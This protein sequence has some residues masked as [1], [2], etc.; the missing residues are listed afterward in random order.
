MTVKVQDIALIT[1]LLLKTDNSDSSVLCDRHS[2][3]DENKVKCSDCKQACDPCSFDSE[4]M[5]ATAFCTECTEYLCKTCLR[6]HKKNKMTRNHQVLI[7]NEVPISKKPFE[8]LK[9]LVCCKNHPEHEVEYRCVDHKEYICSICESRYHRKCKTVEE[10]EPF[11]DAGKDHESAVSLLQ[12]F[13]RN[14]NSLQQNNK[15]K[16]GNIE[17]LEENLKNVNDEIVSIVKDVSNLLFQRGEESKR[18]AKH[19]VDEQQTV[20]RTSV[21]K[22]NALIAEQEDEQQIIRTALTYGSQKQ[23]YLVSQKMNETLSD[24]NSRMVSVVGKDKYSLKLCGSKQDF[25]SLRLCSLTITDNKFQEDISASISYDDCVGSDVADDNQIDSNISHE[26]EK[27]NSEKAN[28]STKSTQTIGDLLG[29]TVLEKSL[30]NCA[31]QFVGTHNI[32]QTGS[33][34]V[35]NINGCVCFDDTI[36]LIDKDNSVLLRFGPHFA[37]GSM[38]DLKREPLGICALSGCSVA[39]ILGGKK[40]QRYLSSSEGFYLSNEF[41]VALHCRGISKADSNVALLM[42]DKDN[43]EEISESDDIEVQVRKVHGGHKVT[44]VDDFIYISGNPAKINDPRC[45]LFTDDGHI[46]I[47]EKNHLSEFDENGRRVRFFKSYKDHEIDDISAITNDDEGNIYVCG[48]GSNNVHQISSTNFFVNRIMIKDIPKPS[49]I[50]FDGKRKR[51]IVGC[52]DTDYIYEFQF[53]D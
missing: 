20:F 45:L 52:E 33:Q 26:S 40:V 16:V 18:E 43:D 36:V 32:R 42:S 5:P 53:T 30:I 27:A 35:C 50:A 1:I 3:K 9:S 37:F 34:N 25:S 31:L 11:V 8:R 4:T 10:I 39:V 46:L 38:S 28:N 47:G 49:C 29:K 17:T 23:L 22:A 24:I 21:E 19:L 48:K 13:D 44:V 6:D 7:D 2:E 14:I 51:L 12:T 15:V 41:S